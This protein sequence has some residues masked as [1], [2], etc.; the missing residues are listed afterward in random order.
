MDNHKDVEGAIK[1]F[2]KKFKDKTKNNW[3]KREDFNAHPGKYTMIEIGKYINT[4]NTS[5]DWVV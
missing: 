3:E 1:S 2:K 4:T 5:Q